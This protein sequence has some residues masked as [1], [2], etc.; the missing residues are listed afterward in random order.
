MSQAHAVIGLTPEG[1]QMFLKGYR[2][3]NPKMAI[4]LTTSKLQLCNPDQ[5]I[6]VVGFIHN[7][8]NGVLGL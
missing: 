3:G 5:I 6:A 1:I 4:R 7:L 2:V 8:V